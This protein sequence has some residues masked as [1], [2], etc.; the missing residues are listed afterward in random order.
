VTDQVA[1][2]IVVPEDWWRITLHPD[3]RRRSSVRTLIAQQFRGLDDQPRAKRDLELEL[4]GAADDAAEHYG[5]MM[6]LSQQTVSGLPVPI[7]LVVRQLPPEI[8]SMDNLHE[9]FSGTDVIDI[10]DLPAGKCLRRLRDVKPAREG[11]DDAPPSHTVDYW[12]DVPTGGTL[13]LTYA[14]PLVMVA[15]ALTELFDAITSTVTWT[16]IPEDTDD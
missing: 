11:Y 5:V 16:T 4:Q 1:A 9:E 3:E 10:A 15:E 2:T 7:S 13:Q 14:S 6:Y 8:G 12:L